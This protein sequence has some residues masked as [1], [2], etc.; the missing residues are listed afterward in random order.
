M[1]G[2]SRGLEAPAAWQ[3][4]DRVPSARIVVETAR[5]ADDAART[6]SL[7]TLRRSAGRYLRIIYV[8]D[9]EPDSVFVITAH[10]LQGKPLAAYRR[11][12]KKKQSR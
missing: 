3:F 5:Y 6:P 7:S 4:A 10:E 11:R 2:R 1:L 12:R 8:P 9:P